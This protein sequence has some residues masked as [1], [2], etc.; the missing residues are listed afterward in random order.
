MSLKEFSVRC[1]AITLVTANAFG[2][3]RAIGPHLPR[4]MAGLKIT[5]HTSYQHRSP[6]FGNG[7][8]RVAQGT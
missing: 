1:S 3:A 4:A 5:T 6:R 8:I 7:C 2:I